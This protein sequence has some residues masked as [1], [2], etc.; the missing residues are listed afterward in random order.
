M[1][2]AA[3]SVGAKADASRKFYVW[4]AA[5][6][7][8]IAVLGFMPTYFL[9]LAQGKFHQPPLIHIHGMIFFS[10]VVF[11]TAQT[12]LVS[13]GRVLKHRDWGLLGI[14]L[15]MAMVFMVFAVV[16]MRINKFERD[17]FGEAARAFSYV[18]ISGAIFFG[19]VIALAIMSVKNFEAHKRLMLLA[20]ISLMDAPIARWFLTFFAP[21]PP[22]GPEQPPPVF[23]AFPPA[24]VADLLV[25]AA[26]TYDWKTR[27]KPHPVWLIGGAA[28]LIEQATRI[29]IS[30]T[31]VWQGIAEALARIG[32]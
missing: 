27:G 4:M 31:P 22:P 29:P 24:L 10:W 12:W 28:L 3:V 6:C 2:D 14:A 30:S 23:V 21:P 8:A 20:T 26:I 1:T 13:S 32:G 17:G 5:T 9:P 15:A 16:V 25:V 19:V 18:Q 11:F 7:L